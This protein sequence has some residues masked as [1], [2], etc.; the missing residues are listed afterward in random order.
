MNPLTMRRVTAYQFFL[1][2]AGYSYDP[3][4]QTPL[5]GRKEC[6]KLLAQ[7]KRR[8]S[9]AGCL[10]TWAIGR[11]IDS[12]DWSDE[13]PPYSLWECL[14]RDAEGQVFASLGGIDFG[15]DGEP[16][17]SPYRRVVEAELATEYAS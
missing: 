11:N 9:D 12:S 1:T 10:F 17:D 7:A 14:A 13:E 16:W 2:H 6:A 5:Q 15:R 4:T 3:K 8:A